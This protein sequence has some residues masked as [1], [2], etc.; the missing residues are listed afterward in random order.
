MQTDTK[1]ACEAFGKLKLEIFG[2]EWRSLSLR[3]SRSIFI[4]WHFRLGVIC[5]VSV[6]SLN[7][8]MVCKFANG[9]ASLR[10][11]CIS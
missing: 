6:K 10:L 4:H 8:K 1:F 3:V 5:H 2:F 7:T 9:V 11:A